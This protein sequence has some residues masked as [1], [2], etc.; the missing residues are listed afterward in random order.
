M[1]R[2]RKIDPKKLKKAVIGM[3]AK[4]KELGWSLSTPASDARKAM[5]QPQ[6]VSV[7]L[8]DSL[9]NGGFILQWQAEKVGFGEI[10]FYVKKKKLICDTECMGPGF[11][12]AAMLHFLESSVLYDP[13]G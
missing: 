7:K 3:E 10:T 1:P 13:K 8:G 2:K 9:A 4:A 5:E 11:V 12:K 6:F